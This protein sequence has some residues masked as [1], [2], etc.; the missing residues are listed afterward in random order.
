VSYDPG[1]ADWAH[2][3]AEAA[4]INVCDNGA[5]RCRL[6][7]AA[8]GAGADCHRCAAERL[9]FPR[10]RCLYCARPMRYNAPPRECHGDRG[11]V[12]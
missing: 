9:M 11:A 6:C 12:A 1:Y 2:A 10:P 8:L 3:S 4:A 7:R 5:G